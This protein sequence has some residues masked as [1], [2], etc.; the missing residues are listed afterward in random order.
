MAYGNFPRHLRNYLYPYV[1]G[2]SVWDLGAGDL[3]HSLMLQELG[4][5]VVAVDK[6]PMPEYPGITTIQ[7]T[8][9]EL[10]VQLEKIGTVF[11]SWPPNWRTG[12]GKI[13]EK[14]STVIYLG[15]NS[16]E[17]GSACGGPT[18]WEEVT[19]RR[20]IISH[21]KLLENTLII[22][23]RRKPLKRAL[24]KEEREAFDQWFPT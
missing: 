3:T 18:F 21:D 4:A 22:Y 15:Q 9:E 6:E 11:V 2:A 24:L 23:G 10:N 16:A 7:K 5:M 1:S 12:L 8:F 20:I 13:V 14:A 17:R 19:Q